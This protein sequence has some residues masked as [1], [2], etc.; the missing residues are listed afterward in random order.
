VV[1]LA[2]LQSRFPDAA[3]DALGAARSLSAGPDE[4]G[5]G[6]FLRRQLGA[7]SITPREGDDPDAILSRAEDHV[8]NGQVATALDELAALPEDARAAMQEW[9]E[10]AQR[11]TEARAAADEIAQRLTA[12]QGNQ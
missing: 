5:L 7:R 10:D 8:R 4:G 1:T 3:R 11:R 9:L 2:N 12:S 6:S